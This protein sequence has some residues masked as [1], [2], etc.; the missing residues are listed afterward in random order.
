[1]ALAWVLRGD[2]VVAIPKSVDPAH[3][4]DNVAAADML[5]DAEALGEV[6]RA[7]APP[8]RGSTLAMN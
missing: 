8:R 6:D 3:L 7:F 2:G 1:V 4:R 5:L